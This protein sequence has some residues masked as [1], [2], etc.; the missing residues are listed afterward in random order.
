MEQIIKDIQELFKEFTHFDFVIDC[1][2]NKV[3]DFDFEKISFSFYNKIEL[4]EHHLQSFYLSGNDLTLNRVKA[5]LLKIETILK[6]LNFGFNIKG[7]NDNFNISIEPEVVVKINEIKL[8]YLKQLSTFIDAFKPPQQIDLKPI[9]TPN[10]LDESLNI[11]FD[12][13]K[14]KNIINS[15][16]TSYNKLFNGSKI[17]NLKLEWL[18]SIGLL[19]ELFSRLHTKYKFENKH[20][21][22]AIF[23]FTKEQY[24]NNKV[25][26]TDK[27]SV[28]QLLQ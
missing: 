22:K 6:D 11:L 2:N 1:Q 9:S 15:N 23:Q 12:R 24:K 13:L 25:S 28:A 18:G 7:A 26:N 20:Y 19:K 17:E 16:K 8:M 27:K 10:I 21:Y 3:L 4:I 14:A 5:E